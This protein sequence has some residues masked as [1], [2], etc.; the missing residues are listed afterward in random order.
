VNFGS[1]LKKNSHTDIG[2]HGWIKHGH[3][4]FSYAGITQI[5]FKGVISTILCCG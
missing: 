3:D 4:I 2:W 1:G 5:R